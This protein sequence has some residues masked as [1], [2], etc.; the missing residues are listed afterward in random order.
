MNKQIP[1]FVTFVLFFAAQTMWAQPGIAVNPS[2]INYGNVAL[3]ADSTQS[4]VITNNGTDDLI[5]SALNIVGN[6]SNQFTLVNPPTL[7]FLLAASQSSSPVKVKFTPASLGNKVAILQILSND[8]VLDTL[9]V[10][11][12]GVGTQADIALSADT[13]DFQSVLLNSGKNLAVNISNAGGADLIITGLTFSGANAPEFRITNSPALPFSIKPGDPPLTL[14]VQFS[15]QTR[16][17]KSATLAISSNDPDENPRTIVLLGT[18]IAPQIVVSPDTLNFAKVLVD[19]DSTL[20]LQI[21]NSGNSDLSVNDLA[22]IG[23]D[24]AFFVLVSPPA[25]PIVISPNSPPIS[26]SLKFSPTTERPFS[27]FL[28]ISS[29]DPNPLPV[30][31]PLKGSG[32]H[33]QISV[34]PAQLAF[35]NVLVGAD[36]ILSFQIS[37]TGEGPLFINDA[38]I[39]GN[40][41][42]EY[43]LVDLPEL[44]IKIN[45]GVTPLSVRIQ[46][47]PASEGLKNAFLT[48]TSN[49]PDG[50][51][52]PLFLPLNG[53]AVKPDLTPTP[54]S[55]AFGRQLVGT[56]AQLSTIIRNQGTADL[57]IDEAMIVGVSTNEFEITSF[58]AFPV[59]LRPGSDSLVITVRFSPLSIGD[60]SAAIA[61]T[62]N[63][64]TANPFLIPLSG[65]GVQPDI[66]A[67]PAPLNF[68]DALVGK[69]SRKSLD[70]I[71]FGQA[72]L[73]ISNL[74]ITGTNATLFSLID[75]PNLPIVLGIDTSIVTLT[76]EFAPDSLGDK[77][78]T[79]SVE[80]NDPD[81]N[82]FNVILNGRGVLPGIAAAPDTVRFD[83][84]RV[85]TDSLI[86]VQISN[87]GTAELVI[88]DTSITGT[89]AAQFF[90]AQSPTLP[91]TILPG[92]DPL[93]II[94]RFRPDSLGVK[95]AA[96][97][98]ISNAANF[99]TLIIPISGEGVLPDIFAADTLDFGNVLVNGDSIA[100][101]NIRN[102]GG[103][104]LTVSSL[105]ISQ[106]DSI[107]HFSL[108][109]LTLPLRIKPGREASIPVKF[110]PDSLGNFNGVLTINSDDPDESQLNIPMKGRGV[111]P[112]IS[113]NTAT[114]DFGAAKLKTPSIRSIW[115]LNLG[116][117]PLRIDSTRISGENRD[118]FALS[119]PPAAAFSVSPGDSTAI[120]IAFTP[121]DRG[122]NQAVL[123]IFSNDP[124]DTVSQVQLKGRGVRAPRINSFTLSDLVL[125]Q[126]ATVDVLVTADTTLQ[127]VQLQ[128][129]SASRSFSRS[130]SLDLRGDGNYAGT[131]PGSDVTTEGLTLIVEVTDQ[132]PTTTRDTLF[133]SVKIPGGALSNT[134]SEN[135][136]N[137][138]L[139][140]SLPYQPV[141]DGDKAIRT[142]L[143]DLGVES[144]ETWR[145]YRTDQTGVNTNYFGL[146]QLEGLGAYG[147]FEPGNAFW[148][149]LRDTEQGGVPVKQIG[150]PEM[151]T[152]AAAPFEYS[153]Q[154]GWNQLGNPFSFPISWDQ[155]SSP[156]K[157]SL[158]IYRWNGQTWD[159]LSTQMGW[160]PLIKT[161]FTLTPWEGYAVFNATASPV[162]LTFD[163]YADSS[164]S[165]FLAKTQSSGWRLMLVAETQQNYDVNIIGMDENA[166]AGKDLL[167]FQNP[168]P[169]ARS[170]VSINFR[171]PEW[172][173]EQSNFSSDFRPLNPAGE[174]WYFD[175]TG[176]NRSVDFYLRETAQL[177]GNFKAML[178]DRKYRQNMDLSHGKRVTLRDVTPGE[179]DRFV[180]LV[181][182]DSFIKSIADEITFIQPEA[183]QLLANYPN[184]FN[185][186]TRIRFQLA[187]PG[188]VKLTIYNLLGQR[189]VT[190]V[191]E[192]RQAGFYETVW[193]GRN[194]AGA[195]TASGVYFYRLRINEF[196]Q[197]LKMLKVK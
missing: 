141:S 84:V 95:T 42:D 18:G 78:A 166:R 77:T 156:Q 38:V 24:N 74:T 39:V 100:N 130:A 129:E 186:E 158:Q 120:S 98:L 167:D 83:S 30:N 178:I 10:G 4:L 123:Q 47:S 165:D 159:S 61:L 60:K 170:Y 146:E 149:Y 59:I 62:N 161:A 147:R 44:P 155:V 180:L 183:Y 54:D 176:S 64:V 132:F 162:Q 86:T 55:L 28:V 144:E 104:K 53:I 43:S 173:A 63:D 52:N 138:W 76:V 188:K 164:G 48:L 73:T 154:S 196:T 41:R 131:I 45:P 136:T 90:F 72:P 15:P 50:S 46:F 115:V 184:P 66:A 168:R 193:N 26:L 160:M 174:S 137:R 185:P 96:L 163:P 157:D 111:L 116:D 81:E 40:S 190:L 99:P 12:S 75:P 152:V 110:T 36:S 182:T 11:L 118:V 37:N 113:L 101:F 19:G 148:L 124:S 79:L 169:V 106:P 125:N 134:F 172:Q 9:N 31:I 2:S 121:P 94:L 34:T 150:F 27:A 92:D 105:A 13:L 1:F 179:T 145:I 127:T 58:A 88:T 22:I 70:L 126:D 85:A 181:G 3:G 107:A 68:G 177:P 197:S 87:S 103:A 135:Q 29:D 122:R 119:N 17:E 67:S 133:A 23:T 171:R 153:L 5:V 25:L 49:D 142:V 14:I 108:Q 117:A 187:A 151:Q 16:G 21:S 82:P 140:F 195:E 69:T 97:T 128:Y 93:P 89:D 91:V 7:P 191:D 33:A 71:N 80:S 139:M 194:S 6:N 35:G 57:R 65:V 8:P 51:D 192:F 56:E 175:V 189:V 32:V 20:N 109:P 114:L 102:S 112:K 143:S